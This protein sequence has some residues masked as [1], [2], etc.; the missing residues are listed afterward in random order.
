MM[1]KALPYNLQSVKSLLESDIGQGR[2]K[3]RPNHMA[4]AAFGKP[5]LCPQCDE[6]GELRKFMVTVII[7]DDRSRTFALKACSICIADFEDFMRARTAGKAQAY[8]DGWEITCDICGNADCSPE[9]H[10]TRPYPEKHRG[11]PVPG[12]ELDH[13][14]CISCESCEQSRRH[15]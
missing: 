2:F 15:Y 1:G 8:Y 10:I 9:P 7:P 13:I 4:R 11:V 6:V 12:T 14:E 5:H 3:R